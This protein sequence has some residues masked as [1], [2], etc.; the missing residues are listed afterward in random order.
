[1]YKKQKKTVIGLELLKLLAV[2]DFRIFTLSDVEKFASQLHINKSYIP[3][4]IYLLVANQWIEKIK[5]GLYAFT[6]ESG[7][8]EP[9]HEFEVAQKLVNPSAIG[10]WTAMQYHQ[11]TQQTPSTI[12][13][14]TPTRIFVP[15]KYQARYVFKHVKKTAYFGTQTIWANQARVQITDLEKTLIDGLSYPELCGGFSEVYNAFVFAKKQLN[16]NIIIKYAFQKDDATKKRLG[17][18]LDQLNF[19]EAKLKKLL[20]HRIKGYRFLNAIGPKHGQCN[21]KWGIIVNI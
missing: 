12:F 18:V 10:F 13:S 8:S 7:M 3:E 11:I 19:S 21:A 4:M 16:L 5:N 15:K 17:W 20:H 2:E 14:I 6:L 9:P 1:M